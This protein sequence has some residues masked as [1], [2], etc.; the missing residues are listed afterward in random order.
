M[1]I[2]SQPRTAGQGPHS[3]HALAV[4]SAEVMP[5][6][7]RKQKRL[8]LL[9]FCLTAVTGHAASRMQ[10]SPTS[11]IKVAATKKVNAPASSTSAR[12][13]ARSSGSSSMPAKAANVKTSVAETAASKSAAAKTAVKTGITRKPISR[14]TVKEHGPT[15]P[16]SERISEIQSALATQGAFQGEPTGRWDSSTIDA[17]KQFQAAHGLNP[18]GKLDAHTLQKLGLGSEVAGR[19]APLPP[20]P[21][22]T[23]SAIENSYPQPDP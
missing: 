21:P 22:E 23:S 9:C 7:L 5:A 17:M 12:P 13:I 1:H 15:A 11:P 3:A 8:A 4:Q 19:G 16:T 18:S 20:L 6:S 2:D 10:E 14:K